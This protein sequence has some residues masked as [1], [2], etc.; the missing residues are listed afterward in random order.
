[1]KLRPGPRALT[2]AGVIALLS[3]GVFFWTPMA[4]LLSISVVLLAG[5]AEYDRRQARQ[6]MSGIAVSRSLPVVIGRDCPFL[7]TLTLTN[8]GEVKLVGEVRD[9]CPDDCDPPLL[10]SSINISAGGSV[11]V[12]HTCRIPRR[13]MHVFG[14]VWVRI[15]GPMGLV[16]V[17]QSFEC[18]GAIRVLPETFAS[19][20]KLVKDF[21]AQLQL[22]D[23]I[24]R[25]RQHG[26][27]TEFESLHPFREGDDPRRIDW[28]ASAK[29]GSPIVRRFQ[30]ER[31]RDV[32]ILIDCGRLMGSLTDTGSKLDCAVDAALNLSRVAL[33]SGD[34]CG[35]AAYDRVVRGFLPP[36]SGINSLGNIVE[37]VYDLQTEWF[38]A[39]FT[40]IHAE[41]QS[42]Q[43]KRSLLVIL[44]DLSDAETSR[45][46]CTALRQLSRRHLVLFAALRT[47][48]LNRVVHETPHSIVDGAR[49]AVT[50]RLIRDR[51]QAL[52]ALE[53]SGVHIL[54]VEPHQLTLPLINQF[55]ELRQRN[56]I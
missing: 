15:A 3:V 1:M 43:G 2:C 11:D 35:V 53:R 14:P 7:S 4:A 18:P 25:T 54:D 10:N 41:L 26:S 20:E 33:Q 31:H 47:P 28:R 45:L 44:S 37:S 16:E 51:A 17:Q 46:Q 38:E 21:G 36:Q 55:V 23:R 12:I 6:R 22:L 30:V 48:L 19:R 52:H 39:D 40:R 24:T 29:H 50:Y 56:L 32:M 42:R 49:H 27:G 9:V 5:A 13:G 34:R 8:S